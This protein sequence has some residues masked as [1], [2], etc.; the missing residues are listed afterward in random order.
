MEQWI[1]E[2]LYRGR[3]PSGPDSAKAPAFHVVIGQQVDS[4][5]EAD[6]K[7]RRMAGPM[8][9]EVAE[10]AGWTFD[11]IIAAMN[12]DAIKHCAAMDAKAAELEAELAA[13]K[14]AQAVAEA[15]VA[16]RDQVLG[17]HNG[18]LAAL[19]KEMMA[20]AAEIARLLTLASQQQAVIEAMGTAPVA[21][22]ALAGDMDAATPG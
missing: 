20:Q 3:P 8:S 14:Q 18:Q 19:S 2:F 11:E 7:Q 12:G 16:A 9:L 22:A 21:S 4:P 13:A 5:F 1:E 17:E 6:V 15:A 10:A